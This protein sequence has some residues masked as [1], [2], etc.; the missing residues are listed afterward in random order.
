MQGEVGFQKGFDAN[1][2]TGGKQKVIVAHGMTMAELCQI[3]TSDSVNLLAS[4]VNNT[5]LDGNPRDRSYSSSVR[6]KAAIALLDRGHGKPETVLKFNDISRAQGAVEQ[7]STNKLLE[8]VND[9][10]SATE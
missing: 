3:H 9:A 10:V 6:V 5:D 7:L 2:F 4:I 8:L 1:R